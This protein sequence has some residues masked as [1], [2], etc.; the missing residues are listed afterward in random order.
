MISEIQ[1]SNFRSIKELVFQPEKLCTLVGPNSA[2]KSNI[3]KAIDL[4]IGEGWTT[5][6]KVA[7]ELFYDT[8]KPINIQITLS[9]PIAFSYF[10]S[11]KQIKYVSLEMT[12]Q[13]LDCKVRLWENSNHS[14]NSGRGYYIN[15][16][17][18]KACHFIYIPSVRDLKDEMRVS[19]WTMLGKLM[20]TIY[21]NYVELHDGEENL[22]TEFEEKIKPAKDF[23]EA[24]FTSGS[25]KVSFKTFYDSFIEFCQGNSVG[26]ANTFE[27][28]LNIYNINWFYKTLQISVKEDFSEKHFDAEDVGSG[29]Q[30]LILLSIFQTYAKLS[31]G[32][33][34]LAME[35]PELFLY[36][37]AQRELYKNFQLLSEN[38]QIFYTTHNP[39][40]IDA[41][42]G[43][44]IE[45]V[46]KSEDVGTF[47]YK[48]NTS[49]LNKENFEAF[50][51]KTYTH[52]NAERNELFFANYILLV[53]GT[54]DKILWST[55]LE[56]KWGIDLNKKGISIIECG[57]KTGVNYFVGVLNIL[58][59]DNYTA[60]WDAD[61]DA[62]DTYNLLATAVANGIGFEVPHN[63]ETFLEAK[64]PDAQFREKKKVEDAYNWSHNVASA[65]IP[66]EFNLVKE[67]IEEYF[68]PTAV[69]AKLVTSSK[70]KE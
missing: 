70:E 65:E 59:R 35:E 53:E 27:P 52:F 5:K 31:G 17:F 24:D 42:R 47:I 10:G 28:H 41:H 23:L 44:E 25:S 55:L 32:K 30:N 46:N 37:H 12:L 13:P 57:G 19:S 67:N 3:L 56:E 22:K 16:D 63:L 7:R 29:M 20:K 50:N 48:K 18:K 39:N 51:S 69:E 14:D 1:I 4:I 43:F 58:G 9:T 38:T 68:K 45:I 26:I 2:G 62:P 36:P 60:I 49:Y 66:A 33:A 61:D 11:E 54:S 8:S 40:F 64:F 34:I 6:A 21:E 15:E